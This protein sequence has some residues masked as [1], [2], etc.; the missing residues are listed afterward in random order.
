MRTVPLA[1]V[2]PWKVRGACTCLHSPAW[3]LLATATMLVTYVP[4]PWIPAYFLKPRPA[5]YIP[6][7]RLILAGPRIFAAVIGSRPAS[8][9]ARR[10]RNSIW[11]PFTHPRAAPPSGA[12]RG[13]PPNWVFASQN[14]L[15]GV[16]AAVGVEMDAA[17]GA[18]SSAANCCI[19]RR[20]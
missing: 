20:D 19:L 5:R 15:F 1:L 6:R 9:S 16:D 13:S 12:A 8:A 2:V 4:E 3:F 17:H 14:W 18:C 10:S 11:A 7:N